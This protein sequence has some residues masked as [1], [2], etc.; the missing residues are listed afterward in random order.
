MTANHDL[1]ED[2]RDHR[3]RRSG[4]FDLFVGRKIAPDAE[5]VAPR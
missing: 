4:T 5:A 1:V 2:T 3:S